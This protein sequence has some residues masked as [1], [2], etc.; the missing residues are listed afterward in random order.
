MQL[1]KKQNM[2]EFKSLHKGSKIIIIETY[3]PFSDN[4]KA[5]IR[6]MGNVDLFRVVRNNSES[7]M[8][9]M[10]SLLE[11]RSGLLHLRTLLGW[12]RIQA[13]FSPMATGCAFNPALRHQN[14]ATPWCST[15]QNWSTERVPY[16]PQRVEEM[17]RKSWRPRRTL[18]RN[19][20]SFSKET[21]SIVNRNS[22]LAVPSRSASRWTMWHRRTTPTVYPKRNF[23]YITNSGISHWTNRARIRRCDF[24][25]TFELQSQSRTSIETCRTYSF[26][27]CI[28]DG[29]FLPQVLH[30]GIGTRPKAGGAHEFNSFFKICCN[31]FRLQLPAIYCNRRGV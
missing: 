18:H 28:K 2:C 12:K 17:L 29:T 3:N 11:T 19:S 14:G 7:A 25:Q 1:W 31:R 6:E 13:T 21:K 10:P 16:R 26:F 15:R 20:R 23:R 30:G 9:S 22:K 4:S 5:M 8:F 27:N 24:D